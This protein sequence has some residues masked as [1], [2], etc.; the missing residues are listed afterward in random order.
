MPRHLPKIEEVDFRGIGE[1]EN[2]KVS[3]ECETETFQTR[4]NE[5]KQEVQGLQALAFS[6]VAVNDEHTKPR[7]KRRHRG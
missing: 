3:L 4:Q 1:P 5:L 2:A 7:F 6:V